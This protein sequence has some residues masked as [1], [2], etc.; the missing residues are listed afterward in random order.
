MQVDDAVHGDR[1][2]FGQI[3]DRM[4]ERG[5]VACDPTGVH[6]EALDDAVGTGSGR[7]LR[8]GDLLGRDADARD[9]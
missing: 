6:A 8:Q 1:L 9:A 4:A 7:E 5:D 2:G 3:G